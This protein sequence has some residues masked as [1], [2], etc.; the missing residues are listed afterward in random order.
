[1]YLQNIVIG[2]DVW[3]DTT[4]SINNVDLGDGVVIG[5]KCTVFGK[6]GQLLQIGSFTK[7]GML[8]ILN[9][10]SA[11][12]K[13]GAYCSIGPMC[14]FLV[15]SGPTASP[16]LLVKYPI[17]SAPITIGDHCHIGASCMIIAG[18]TIGEGAVIEPN[19]FVNGKV[20]AH[21][22]YGGNPAKFI[23]RIENPVG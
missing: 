8:S 15:D 17:G 11:L 5:K 7:V 14:H 12:L 20:E 3:V 13:I 6:D 9:G 18:A 23:R 2:K 10:Y 19:S 21:C 1:M 22:V 4:A 16:R